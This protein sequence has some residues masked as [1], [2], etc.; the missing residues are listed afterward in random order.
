MRYCTTEVLRA[1]VTEAF[2]HD[3]GLFAQTSARTWR[4]IQLFYYNEGLHTDVLNS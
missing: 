2:T 3:P 1:A 4:R